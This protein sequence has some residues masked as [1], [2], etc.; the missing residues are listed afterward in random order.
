MNFFSVVALLS[1]VAFVAA[2][3]AA[4]PGGP[5]KTK[6]YIESIT[7]G[8]TGCPQGTVSKSISDD[9]TTFTLIFDQYIAS[10]GPNVPNTESRKACQL[11]INLKVPSGWSYTVGTVDY[12]GYVQ[13]PAGGVGTHT[14]TYYF[15]GSQQQCTSS[16]RFTGP[17]AKD[18]KERDTLGL[19]TVVWCACGAPYALNIKNQIAV[20]SNPGQ[21]AQMTTD[22]ID[23]KFTQT[24]GVLWRNC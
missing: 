20:T 17:I 21:S 5:D 9:R 2:V 10:T 24:F 11:N 6:V 4:T 1:S 23:G 15:S 19:N 14:S 13:L 16:R 18:Y 3:P 22:S 7:Y 8:G 12:R